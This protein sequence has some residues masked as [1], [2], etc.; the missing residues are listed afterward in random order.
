MKTDQ[1]SMESSDSFACPAWLDSDGILSIAE[2]TDPD[3][4][5]FPSGER[6]VPNRRKQG[7]PRSANCGG[8]SQINDLAFATIDL[9]TLLYPDDNTETLLRFIKDETLKDVVLEYTTTGLFGTWTLTG[10]S[11]A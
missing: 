2:T 11:S 3:G 1:R 7:A 10:G 5:I 4:L 6:T 9:T 8:E